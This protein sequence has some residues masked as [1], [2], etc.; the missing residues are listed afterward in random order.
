MKWKAASHEEAAAVLGNVA[1]YGCQV[2][3]NLDH[4]LAAHCARNESVFTPD[5]NFS[6]DQSGSEAT[7]GEDE[8][9]LSASG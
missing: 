2:L 1:K 4:H 5:I 8:G 6:Q 7:V 9:K 3:E